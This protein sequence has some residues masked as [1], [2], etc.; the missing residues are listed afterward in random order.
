LAH[1]LRHPQRQQQQQMEPMFHQQLLLW[2]E[3]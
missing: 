2:V 1:C 3:A